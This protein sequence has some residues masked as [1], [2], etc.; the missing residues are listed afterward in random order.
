MVKRIEV[1]SRIQ[2]SVLD[3]IITSLRIDTRTNPTSSPKTMYCKTWDPSIPSIPDQKDFIEKKRIKLK[4]ERSN[5]KCFFIND[6][7]HN[8]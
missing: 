8:M 5:A 4:V 7:P 2:R 1:A 3:L 6:S